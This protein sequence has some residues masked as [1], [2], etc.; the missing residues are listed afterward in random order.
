M[1]E[2]PGIIRPE[3]QALPQVRD[4]MT[5]L[6]LE[7]CTLGRQDGAITVTDENGLP[8]AQHDVDARRLRRNPA[9]A[10]P[11]AAKRADR[12]PIKARLQQRGQAPDGTAHKARR[13]YASE[14][15]CHIIDLETTG[16]QNG[17]D[18]I[19]EFGAIRVLN[20]ECHACF[21]QLVRTEKVLPQAIADLTGISQAML[22]KDGVPLSEALPAFLDFIG[23]E[24]LIGYNLT[25]DM[26]FLR[27]ACK[28]HGKPLPQ[29]RCL[30][31]LSLARRKI[32]SVPNYKL[33]TLTSHLSLEGQ[34]PHRA[35]AD[36]RLL[37]ALYLKLN[38]I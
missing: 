3:L 36:C 21:S 31:L 1:H 18:Q 10:P 12:I 13:R 20:G 11:S 35:L 8:R 15:L 27:T 24:Q 22:E 32:F 2:V 5:F 23:T 29:N 7:H 30:D 19:L 26:A 6:Y 25:F 34:T 33:A 14:I 9:D 16:L 4:R 37:H 17:A 38:E 28:A